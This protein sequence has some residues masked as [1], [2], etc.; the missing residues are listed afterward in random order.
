MKFVALYAAL[1][2]SLTMANGPWYGHNFLDK[3]NDIAILNGDVE[4]MDDTMSRRLYNAKLEFS[5]DLPTL[6]SSDW[7]SDSN[8]EN[9]KRIA[10]IFDSA[11]FSDIFP[12]ADE[13]YSYDI[14]ME[15][16]AYY[17]HFCNYV[18][19]DFLLDSH[20]Q[21][22]RIELSTYFSY[23]AVLSGANDYTIS[24]PAWQ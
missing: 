21:A 14:M 4:A 22:C 8:P 1:C 5:W 10:E 6:D 12:L 11:G 24:T 7:T 2:V 15:T 3:Y 13:I 18:D 9:I 19:P 16:F 20:E 17:P 23:L